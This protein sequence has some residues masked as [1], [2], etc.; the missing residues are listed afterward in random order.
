[1]HNVGPWAEEAHQMVSTG[2]GRK[3]DPPLR[4]GASGLV[5]QRGAARRLSAAAQDNGLD[6]LSAP[7]DHEPNLN[8]AF[9]L[10]SALR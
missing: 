6:C 7:F 9:P 10:C 2:G 1:L 8:A 3:T 4:A 5:R